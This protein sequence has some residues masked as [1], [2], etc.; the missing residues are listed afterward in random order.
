MLLTALI[1]VAGF[2]KAIIGIINLLIE[3]T[4]R[5][6]RISDLVKRTGVPRETIHYYTREGLLPKPKKSSRNQADYSDAHVEGIILIKELQDRFF[7]PLS[8]IKKIINKLKKTSAFRNKLN[9]LE[10]QEKLGGVEENFSEDC[11]YYK[12]SQLT[13][14]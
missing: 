13:L 14:D 3:T 6:M 2:N 4:R 5:P 10:F 9:I 11:A 7:L 8:A 12:F 1:H